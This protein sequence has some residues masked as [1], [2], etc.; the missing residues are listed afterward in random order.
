MN[1]LTDLFEQFSLLEITLILR[2]TALIGA[3]LAVG[4]LVVTGL[5]GHF[6]IGLGA[7]IG[8]VLGLVNIRLVTMS[9]ARAGERKDSKVR[10][11][12][13]SNTMLRLGATTAIIFALVF[14]V[15]DLGLGTLAGVAL[16]YFI[17][18]GN[19]MRALF[20]QGVTA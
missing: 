3:I 16:F 19:V 11:V 5:F 17:F 4:A 15:R 18:L 13:A 2:R 20:S 7:C 8:L 9:V 12:I 10:R 1:R 14:T 6:L